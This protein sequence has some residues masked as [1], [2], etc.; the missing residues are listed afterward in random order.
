M[1]CI[2]DARQQKTA[3]WEHD[4]AIGRVKYLDPNAKLLSWLASD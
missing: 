1:L 2:L 3:T 4:P